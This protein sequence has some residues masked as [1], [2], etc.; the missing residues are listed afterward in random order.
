[1]ADC[2][3]ARTRHRVMQRIHSKDT[4]PEKKVRRALR[5]LGHHYYVNRTG[6]PGSPDIVLPQH[7]IVIMINGCFWHQHPGCKLSK[8]PKTNRKFWKKKFAG[9]LSRDERNLK[10]LKEMCGGQRLFMLVQ[11]S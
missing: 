4:G 11:T 10:N 7:N 2:Y 3:D 8:L 1:M 6:L 9:N 5:A